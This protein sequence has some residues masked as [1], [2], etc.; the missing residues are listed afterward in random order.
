METYDE[1]FT[2]TEMGVK[3]DH[4]PTERGWFYLSR[5]WWAIYATGGSWWQM[6]IA[7]AIQIVFVLPLL[8]IDLLVY[9]LAQILLQIWKLAIYMGNFAMKHII[10]KLLGPILFIV[11][12]IL[13]YALYNLGVWHW[14]YN[15]I[16]F[17][18][19]KFVS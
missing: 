6:A 16:M 11:A 7:H 3:L 2:D 18:L 8:V 9:L 15:A 13:I 17:A 1:T 14:L 4:T 5:T 10:A 19:R 12:G